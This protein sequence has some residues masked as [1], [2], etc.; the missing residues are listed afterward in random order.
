MKKILILF[1]TFLLF[2]SCGYKPIYS[3]SENSNYK[4][5][6][7][8]T[9]G[10]KGINN[11]I[12]RNLNQKFNKSDGREITTKIKSN[13]S[14]RIVAKNAK[15]S[16]T[17]YELQINVNFEMV[18]KGT[19]KVFSIEE[20]LNIKKLDDILKEKNYEKTVKKNLT[21]SIVDKL[22]LRISTFE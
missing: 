13:Y 4:I 9:E 22:I 21:S 17:D 14:K 12:V 3:E 8:S 19:K 6:I 11:L 15:G 2:S 10:D 1:L 18:L 7:I 20:R 5:N 16:V